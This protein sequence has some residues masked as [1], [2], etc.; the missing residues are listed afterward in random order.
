MAEAIQLEAG[1]AL[2]NGI[3]SAWEGKTLKALS[4]QPPPGDASGT[5]KQYMWGKQY[6][7]NQKKYQQLY[8]IGS[9]G[10][11]FVWHCLYAKVFELL[12]KAVGSH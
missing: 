7:W 3:L 1:A 8:S 4:P 12:P 11:N 9:R 2:A 6:R 5:R 10:L